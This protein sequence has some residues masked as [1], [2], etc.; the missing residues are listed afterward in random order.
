MPPMVPEPEPDILEVIDAPRDY[1]SEKIVNFTTSIDHFFG[2]ERY[3]QES[4][5][6]V[7]QLDF[8]ETLG[9][10]GNRTFAFEGK[11]KVHLPAAEKRF[12]FVIESN[13]EKKTAGEVKKDLPE[14]TKQSPTP[15]QYA[16]SLRYEQKEE[17]SQWHFSSEAGAL[18]QFPLEFFVKSRGS[19]AIPMGDWRM[20]VAETLFWFRTIGLGETT[21]LDMEHVISDPVLF[22]ATSTATC[23]EAPQHCDL[24]QDFSIFQ[25]LDERAALLYQ[26]S[27][28][29]AD[30]PQLEETAYVLLMKYRYR[31]H[32]DWIFYEVSPQL[33]F[34]RTDGFK[35]NASLLLRLEVLFGAK[36]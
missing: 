10:G 31:L 29:G 30:K 12:H 2:D 11:A 4:N 33:N 17:E 3:F 6:S 27:V 36:Q 9:Q 1:L 8:A 5:K 34:P 25:T 13:P 26:A 19:V 7:I 32:K 18:F 21:Q 23:F 15:D 20:K 14:T 28:I 16:A 22:R 24:R 35:V